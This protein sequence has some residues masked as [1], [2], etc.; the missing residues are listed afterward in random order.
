[1]A[2]LDGRVS[3][4]TSPGEIGCKGSIFGTGGNAKARGATQK[5]QKKVPPLVF[6]L[7]LNCLCFQDRSASIKQLTTSAAGKVC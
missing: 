1:M 5:L 6:A 4:F 2:V 7:L 3:M